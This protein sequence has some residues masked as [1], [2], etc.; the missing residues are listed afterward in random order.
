VNRARALGAASAT[1][2]LLAILALSWWGALDE[3]ASLRTHA[4][5]QRALVTFALTR[6]LNGAI[7]VAQG[8][9]LAFEP[10][11]VG[12]VISAGEILDPLNDLVEQFSWLALLAATSLGIQIMLG[13]MFATLPVNGVLSVAIVL[14][15]VALWWPSDRRN[16]LRAAVLRLT[17]TFIFLRFAVVLASIGTGF[18]NEYFLAQ[19]EAASVDF[20][21]QTR[22]QLESP[23]DTIAPSPTSQDSLLERFNTF[24]DDQ[25][26]ALDVEGRLTRLKHD[27]ESAVEHVVNLIVVY[28][29]ETLLLPLGFLV[30]SWGLVKQAW[31][32]IG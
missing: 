10:A 4:A 13:E 15:I 21:S 31:R 30:V 20:L 1:M 12:V 9:E 23:D 18:V 32:R 25:R 8:T 22:T 7:S 26:R 27:V 5:L 11:G 24:I 3:V 19:R 29:I 14:S 6:T 28:V 17:A 2:L 16:T